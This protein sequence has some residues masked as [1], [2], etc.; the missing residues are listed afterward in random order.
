MA[1]E[2]IDIFDENNNS[3]VNQ[4]MKGE[5][6]RDGLWHRTAHIWIYNSKGE[7]LLQLRAKDK[8]LYP[9]VWDISA[10][11]HVSAGEDPITSGL[12]EIKEEIGL[13]A[14]Q[15]DLDFWMIRKHE[16]VFRDIKNNEFYYVYFLKFDGDIS[17][18]KLQDEEVQEIKFLP[19]DEVKEDL[20]TNPDRYV[21]HGD[22][23]FEALSEIKKRLANQPI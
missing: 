14:K 11:G 16:A 10:A 13:K 3:V 17:Q 20:K 19:I 5:A 18:L 9:D 22:Y 15:E 6:H 1:D 8:L 7:I 12:R 2:L 4:K 23:W 21:P